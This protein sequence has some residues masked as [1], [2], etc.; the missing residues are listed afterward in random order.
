VDPVNELRVCPRTKD[1]VVEGRFLDGAGMNHAVIASGLKKGTGTELGDS[2]IIVANTQDGFQNAVEVEVIGVIEEPIAQA[3][4]RL[5]YLPMTTAQQ[6]LYMEDRVNEIVIKSDGLAGIDALNRRINDRLRGK[7]LRASTWKEVATFFVDVMR[8]Q[9]VIIFAISVIFFFIVMSSITNTMTL[10]VFERRKEIGTMMAVGIK[11]RY[12][13][14]L[15]VAE[16]MVI[17]LIGS[18]A[19]TL[20]SAAAILLIAGSGLT[21]TPP[22]SL[23]PISIRPVISPLFMLATFGLGIASAV[24]ASIYPARRTLD[25]EPADALREI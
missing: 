24:A 23:V 1:N 3:N 21:R 19:G 5:V 22:G 2:V 12:I 11:A 18:A 7:L 14:G 17:G 6:L 13:T 4:R 10:A 9:N 25:V 8:K 20:A 15:I 16:S